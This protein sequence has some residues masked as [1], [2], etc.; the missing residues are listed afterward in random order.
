MLPYC[1]QGDLV[2]VLVFVL[3]ASLFRHLS[4]KSTWNLYNMGIFLTVQNIYTVFNI[5]STFNNLT[6]VDSEAIFSTGRIIESLVHVCYNEAG[7][8]GKI[9]A[10]GI[11]CVGMWLYTTGYGWR[12]RIMEEASPTLPV[13]GKWVVAWIPACGTMLGTRRKG[14][15][16]I[17]PQGYIA[18]SLLLLRRI[19][20]CAFVIWVY[21]S[22]VLIVIS[23]CPQHGCWAPRAAGVAQ[24]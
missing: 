21:L 12:C 22:G 20:L 16:S 1:G 2:L 8:A 17:P 9:V 15:W 11:F 5:G 18:S 10:V 14:V 4:V 19:W 6:S 23:P 3:S 13:L 24:L 7:V